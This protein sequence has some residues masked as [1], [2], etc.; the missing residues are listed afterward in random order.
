MFLTK[1]RLYSK[2]GRINYVSLTKIRAYP[3]TG[4]INYAFLKRL[5]YIL[6]LEG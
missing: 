5:E 2:T 1:I 4:R 3:T 6:I